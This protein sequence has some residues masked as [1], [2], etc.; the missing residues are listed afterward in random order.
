M[1]GSERMAKLLAKWGQGLGKTRKGVLG[2]ISEVF[3]G[4]DRIDS[5]LLDALEEI[6]IEADVGVET[7]T[8]VVSDL[9]KAVS[10]G[11]DAKEASVRSLLKRS[12]MDFVRTDVSMTAIAPQPSPHVILVVGVNG[13][14][15]TTSIGK[16]AH[17]YKQDG[18][19]VLLA[20]AD[21]F[22]AAAAE[23]LDVWGKRAK[24][25]VIRQGMGADAASVAYDALDAAVARHVDI[26]IVDTAGRLHTKV[27]LMEELKK[28]RRVLAKR[29]DGAPQE[30]LLVLDAITGQN[31]LSQAR[32]FTEAVGVTGIVLTKLDGTARGGI[33]VAIHRNLGIPVKWVGVGERI[34][35]LLVFDPVAFVEGM[36][37]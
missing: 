29:M 4:K 5:S 20:C 15:K 7:A 17:H 24:A 37:G 6:L 13:T 14:G 23:Q 26:L 21:T 3:K 12:M 35:D 30:V 16:L 27:N 28:V 9:K 19:K 25:D 22:R 11:A 31:G 8:E 1:K 34:E 33:V 18:K 10:E 32:L 36:F 2:R